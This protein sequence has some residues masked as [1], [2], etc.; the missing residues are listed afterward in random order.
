MHKADNN[1]QS[2][3]SF[4]L[5]K[6]AKKLIIKNIRN[7]FVRWAIKNL[8]INFWINVEVV[9]NILLNMV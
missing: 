4:L 5:K 7:I 3:I 2:I 1:R 8:K 9:N 6:E